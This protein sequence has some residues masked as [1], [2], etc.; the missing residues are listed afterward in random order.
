MK[1]GE[2]V[3]VDAVRVGSQTTW[4]LREGL[5]GSASDWGE[6]GATNGAPE[7]HASC[8]RAATFQ[9]FRPGHDGALLFGWVGLA[10]G[11]T[12]ISLTSPLH[13]Y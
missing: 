10:V 7:W 1:V 3:E 12:V 4:Q 5:S 11:E 8:G 6:W 9:C 2:E 13:P